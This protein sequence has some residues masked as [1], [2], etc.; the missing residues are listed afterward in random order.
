MVNLV[1]VF[2]LLSCLTTLV[3]KRLRP[4]LKKQRKAAKEGTAT[5]KTGSGKQRKAKTLSY[6][7]KAKK[8]PATEAAREQRIRLSE[9]GTKSFTSAGYTIHWPENTP[10]EYPIYP[11]Y[12]E[13]GPRLN[14]VVPQGMSEEEQEFIFRADV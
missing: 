8:K 3:D 13:H 7:P 5:Q 11:Q 2:A 9:N 10:I 12:T 14:F 1:V 4:S 6:V